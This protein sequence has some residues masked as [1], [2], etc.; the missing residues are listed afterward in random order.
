M[1]NLLNSPINSEETELSRNVNNRYYL[2]SVIKSFVFYVFWRQMDLFGD[3]RRFE[4]QVKLV[5]NIGVSKNL[6]CYRKQTL[7]AQHYLFQNNG[8]LRK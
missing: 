8:E 7:S 2:I 3:F 6:A 1:I 4:P 5:Q